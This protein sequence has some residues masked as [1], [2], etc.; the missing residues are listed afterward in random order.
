MKI[1]KWTVGLAAAG[2]V[3]LTP[4]LLAQTSP[5]PQLVPM[6]TALT[7]TTISGY[8]DTSAVWNPGTGNA[9]PAPYAFNHGKQD[10]FNLNAVDVK[11]AKAEDETQWSAGYVAELSYGPDAQAI[12]G[13]AYPIR[14]AYVSMRV[15][16]GN[17]LDFD[18]GRWDS[19][20]G[21]ESSDSMKN[22]NYTRSYGKTF[23]P[24]EN[25][26]LLA[27][28][29]F[30]DAFSLQAG[31]ADTLTTTGYAGGLGSVNDR[32]TTF[33]T[34]PIESKKAALV[35]GTLT[36]PDSWGS[37]K[38]STLVAGFDD[39][40]GAT[41]HNREEVYVG[42]T[43]NT[44]ITGLTFGGS[45]DAIFHTDVPAA[46]ATGTADTD[47]GYFTA[48][49]GYVSYKATDKLTLN[50]RVE[51]ATG[52]VLGVLADDVNGTPAVATDGG[53]VPL[54]N[55]LD[56]VLALTGTVQYDLWENVISRLEIRWDH[57]C[58]GADAFGGVGAPGETPGG[59]PSGLPN[60]KNEVTLAANVIYKF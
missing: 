23:E 57:A 32:V 1:E 17:G 49:A 50:G 21:Y 56:K 30:C 12:D 42:T 40:Q 54:A 24:T 46:T 47:E 5:G 26:G 28:Y 38:G 13:G 29:K 53:N 3:S 35:L 18:L 6:Q 10:G 44:P 2:L 25:T 33:G 43:V 11:I 8:V 4:A 48:Y 36:A 37:F 55:P 60:K 58:N 22:P 14:Q 7:A 27:S 51:Y 41:S 15:P 39:G 16:V 31:V 9:N 59:L 52:T 20:L 34:S 45:W 19:L